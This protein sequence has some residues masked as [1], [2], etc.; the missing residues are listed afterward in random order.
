MTRRVGESRSRDFEELPFGIELRPSPGGKPCSCMA[1][2]LLK[3]RSPRRGGEA[4]LPD[5]QF[6][7]SSVL[8]VLDGHRSC[9]FVKEA[10][11]SPIVILSQRR[12]GLKG[13]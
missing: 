5:R 2:R 6:A 9:H 11:V 4:D 10:P 7:T 1:E 8:R 13:P 3:V 12:T